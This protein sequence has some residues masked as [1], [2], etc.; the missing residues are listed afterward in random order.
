MENRYVINYDLKFRCITNIKFKQGDIDSSVLELHLKDNGAVVDI[1]GE[2]IEFRF[3]KFDKTVVYQNSGIAADKVTI[4]DAT[5]GVVE[6]IVSVNALA[7]AGQVKCE[8]HRDLNG[9]E[10]TT[11][12]F[13]FTVEESIGANGT[14]S[15]NYIGEIEAIKAA[16]DGATKANLSVEVYNTHTGADGKTYANLPARLDA[17]DSSLA[18]MSNQKADVTYVNNQVQN[19]SSQVQGF[20]ATASALTTAF[21]TG[22]TNNYVVTA[23]NYIYRWNGSAWVSTGV[24]F[25]AN[26]IAIGAV[27][28]DKL[29]D[30]AGDGLIGSYNL[31]NLATATLGSVLLSNDTTQTVS[32]PSDTGYSDYIPVIVG[33]SYKGFK[34]YSYSVCLNIYDVNKVLIKSV[35]YSDAGITRLDAGSKDNTAYW[36]K[37]TINTPNAVYIRTNFRNNVLLNGMVVQ[38]DDITIP[39]IYKE[40]NIDIKSDKLKNVL[41]GVSDA[42]YIGSDVILAEFVQQTISIGKGATKEDTIGGIAIGVNALANILPTNDATTDGKYN[43]AIGHFSMKNMTLL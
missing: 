5:N 25:N 28:Y 31:N 36:W 21:P 11:P 3:L 42:V 26:G 43:T 9:K 30:N 2:V 4:L 15:A 8:I 22:N 6:C 34:P 32:N 17:N 16:Y 19:M 7:L 10:L 33:L 13:Y 40:Y 35:P 24:L 23:D 1:T 18:N 37:Y 38:S 12:S 39:A 41:Q 27:T 29:A 20:Y 14:I